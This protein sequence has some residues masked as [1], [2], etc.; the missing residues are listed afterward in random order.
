MNNF[1]LQE[2]GV[3]ESKRM[4]CYG[5]DLFVCEAVDDGNHQSLIHICERSAVCPYSEYLEKQGNVVRCLLLKMLK[6]QT[7]KYNH[8]C[9]RMTSLRE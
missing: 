7:L 5:T 3:V 4:T 2:I 1:E 6:I 9:S 8:E